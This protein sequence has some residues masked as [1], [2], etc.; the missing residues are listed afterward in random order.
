MQNQFEVC[1]IFTENNEL[2]SLSLGFESHDDPYDILHIVSGKS[3]SNTIP[4]PLEDHLYFERTD[5]SLSCT[6]EVV[7]IKVENQLI[8]IE[9]TE[10]G[11]LSLGFDRVV[12][13]LFIH[14]PELFQQAKARLNEMASIGYQD[15]IF[16]IRQ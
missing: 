16:I 9:F 5:Q 14:H 15:I 3:L 4:K 12:E 8:K 6:G 2:I 1:E 13:F 7:A 10:V 11:S